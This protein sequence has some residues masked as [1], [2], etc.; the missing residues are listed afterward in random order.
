MAEE[1][2]FQK[3]K[4]EQNCKTKMEY[5]VLPCDFLNH[6]RTEGVACDFHLPFLASVP[7]PKPAVVLGRSSELLWGVTL[8]L[9]LLAFPFLSFFEVSFGTSAISLWKKHPHYKKLIVFLPVVLK[10]RYRKFLHLLTLNTVKKTS[11][12]YQTTLYSVSIYNLF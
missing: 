9:A 2:T 11:I 1:T 10:L 8:A 6:S 3:G 12:H 5:W 7:D 4:N